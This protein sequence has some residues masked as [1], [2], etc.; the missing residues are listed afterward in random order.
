MTKTAKTADERAHHAA[1]MREYMRTYFVR[2]PEKLEAHR[3]QKRAA[4]RRY[5]E[6]HPDRVRARN[7]R[8][9][10]TL[11]PVQKREYDRQYRTRNKDTLRE[12][13][14]TQYARLTPAEKL[15]RS[16]RIQCSTYGITVADFH[17]MVARQNGCCAVCGTKP[18]IRLDI[19]H[20]HASGAVRGLL[21]RRC[22]LALGFVE[23]GG[24]AAFARKLV[25]YIQRTLA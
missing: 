11:S 23:S 14:R 21:C 4:A 12:R 1:Y 8:R 5:A 17:A 16:L 15:A 2:F 19:D 7:Q 22:N 18:K 3:E 6:R 20:N 25:A 9:R 10:E 24:G 13:Q